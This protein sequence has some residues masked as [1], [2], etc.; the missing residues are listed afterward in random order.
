[1]KIFTRCFVA[2]LTISA[3]ITLAPRPATAQIGPGMGQG[4]PPQI[5][6]AIQKEVQEIQKLNMEIQ[7]TIT[8]DQKKKL[9][10]VQAKYK[11]LADGIMAP[12]IKKYGNQPSQADQE[13]IAKELKPKMATMQASFEKEMIAM[14]KPNQVT[15]IN[16]VKAMDKAIQ[17][18]MRKMQPSAK[19]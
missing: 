5:P 3:L 12:Y 15:M 7:K 11:K 6:P 17:E 19:K 1:M 13:K 10:A 9:G 4:Q 16:K 14:M 8:P 18:K 2:L